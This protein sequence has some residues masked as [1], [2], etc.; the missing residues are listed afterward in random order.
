LSLDLR[1][2]EHD[3]EDPL[4][5]L[6]A[7]P[8]DKLRKATLWWLKRVRR[9]HSLGNEL[10]YQVSSG[11]LRGL[12]KLYFDEDDEPW[13]PLWEPPDRPPGDPRP[14]YRIV[15]Q[16]LPDDEQPELIEVISIGPKP[17]VYWTAAERPGRE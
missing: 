5:D 16:V 14:R 10:G 6:K 7:L 8:S 15:Y 17:Q 12:Y 1:F 13:N 2:F 4:A 3:D 9:D 11:D